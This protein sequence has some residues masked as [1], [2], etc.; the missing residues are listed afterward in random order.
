M[1]CILLYNTT[2][3]FLK[4]LYIT[5]LDAIPSLG[6]LVGVRGDRA[7]IEDINRATGASSYFGSDRDRFRDNHR[8]FL[9]KFVEPIRRANLSIRNIV[10]KVTEQDEYRRIESEDDLRKIPPCM[11]IPMLTYDPMYSLLRQ[12]RIDGW[13]FV[14]E[15]L[16]EE[17]VRYDRLIVTN[18]R[19]DLNTIERDEIGNFT[20]SSTFESTD[21]WI[22]PEHREFLEDSRDFI[23]KVLDTTDLDPTDLS[24][25]KG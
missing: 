23:Q 25:L 3:G 9:T 12:G 17:K 14:A 22:T 2:K 5:D 13:G 11:M 4:M 15:N 19:A 21:P 10:N 20:V 24:A 18:G 7:L 6:D 8:T 16:D 1:L